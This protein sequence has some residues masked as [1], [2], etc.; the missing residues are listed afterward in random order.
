MPSSPGFAGKHECHESKRTRT[1][2]TRAA[3]TTRLRQGEAACS[4]SDSD[5]DTD[6]WQEEA[7]CSS[8]GS[9]GDTDDWQKTGTRKR[10]R[11][12]ARPAAERPADKK[13]ADRRSA[14]LR[15]FYRLLKRPLSDCPIPGPP[16][17]PFACA[18]LMPIARKASS[19]SGEIEIAKTKTKV[20]RL[21]DGCVLQSGLV[22]GWQGQQARPP[23]EN[24]YPK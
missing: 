24:K 1:V 13:P 12:C 10:K 6:D 19:L 7:A 9:N 8:S 17:A 23:P 11:G 21:G 16:H 4:S 22:A 5:S 15:R 2:P 20:F 14:A 3:V 18:R